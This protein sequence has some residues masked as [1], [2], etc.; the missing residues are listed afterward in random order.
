MVDWDRVE[1]LRS[2]EWDWAKIA[3]D[4]KVGFHA[5]SSA[6]D[7]GRALRALYHRN[8]SRVRRKPETPSGGRAGPAERKNA[9]TLIRIGYLLVPLLAIWFV[10]AYFIP[11]PVGLLVPAVPYLG[12]VL[13][14]VAFLLIFALWRSTQGPRWSTVFRTTLV[15]GIVLGFV[16]A[17]LIGIAS[18]LLFGCPYLPPASSETPV[19]GS[20]WFKISANSWQDSG[21]PVL[22]YYGSTWCPF[23]SGSSWVLWKTLSEFGGSVPASSFSDYSSSSDT[24]AST[25]EVV[26]ANAASSSS[27]AIQVAEDTS[28]VQGTTPGTASCYQQAYLTAY[29][30]GGIPFFV[31]NGQYVHAGTLIDPKA[32]SSYAA[33]Q[34]GGDL[35]VK[36]SIANETNTAPWLAV[37][38]EAWWMM[39]ILAKTTGE[40]LAFLGASWSHAT[41][42]GVQADYNLI[43]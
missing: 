4:P 40:S 16:I 8:R 7:P 20:G 15:W 30:N 23:C 43:S 5:D 21:R 34:N 29:S 39:A 3:A 38:G 33:G 9:W 37:Q 2:K 36:N 1:E 42:A 24:D 18:T 27:V 31:I 41:Q 13:A 11:S 12:L 32:L 14:I 35:A 17:G 28:G 22:F 26:L 19:A 6:G 25:P 10:V